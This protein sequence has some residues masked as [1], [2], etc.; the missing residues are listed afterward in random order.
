MT[1]IQLSDHLFAE[2]ANGDFFIYRYKDNIFVFRQAKNGVVPPINADTV[3]I[4]SIHNGKHYVF[5]RDNGHYWWEEFF[6]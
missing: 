3:E 5:K 6:K 2:I 1:T 4:I